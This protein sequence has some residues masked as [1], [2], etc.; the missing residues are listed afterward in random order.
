MDDVQRLLISLEGRFNKYE[1]DL[2]RTKNRTRTNFRAME[3]QAADSAKKMDN[4]MAGALKSFG[5][6]LAGG[7]IGGLAIGGLDQ[8]VSR[9]G[10]IA[11][12]IASIGN[13]AKR[14]GL[15]T[16]AFQELGYVAQQNRIPVDA[17]VDGMKELNLR[18][19]EF[20]VTGKGSAAEAFQRLG[21]SAQDLKRKLEDPS[22]LLVEIIGR[23]Q[24]LDRA[25]Q[26][27]IADEIFGGTGGERF[28]ELI[29]QGAEGIRRAIKEANDLGIVMDDELIR[30]A[31]ELDRKFQAIGNTISTY[32]KQ[33]VV[34]LVGA[35]D[36]FLDR[37]N[38]V[39]EQSDRNVQNRLLDTYN[40][41]AAEKQKLADL[42]QISLGTPADLMNITAS[43]KEIERLTAEAM[44]LRD[45]LDRRNGYREDFIYKT[46]E[47]AK[48]AKPPLDSLNN[49]LTGTGSAAGAGAKGLDSF[50]SAVRALKDEVPDLANGLAQLDAQTRIDQAYRAALGQARTMGEVYLANELRGNALS[51]VAVRSAT[52]DP[53]RYLTNVLASGKSQAHINGLASTFAEKLAKMLASMPDDLKGS[54]T[55]NSGYRS[56]ERQ[57]QL[58]LQALKKYGSP[59]AARKWVAPPGNSQHNKGNAAD[60]GYSS[61]AARQW[62]HGNASRFGLTFPLSNENWHIEDAEARQQLNSQEME[63]K[64]AVATE[65][66]DAYR[67]ITTEARNF[68]LGQQTERQ[69]LDMT[70]DAAAAL[71]YEQQMLAEAQR[72]GI[73]LTDQQ[74]Q[75]IANLAAGM[76]GAE[77]A[78]QSYVQT[79]E[80]ASAAAQFFGQQAVDALSGLLTGTM[81][82]EHALQQLLQ[83]LVKAALQAALLGEGPLAGLL[84][85]KP[86]A[87][88]GNGSSKKGLGSILGAIFGFAD[89]GY[90]GHGGKHEPAGVVHRGEY[91]MSKRAVERIGVANLEA[92]HRGALKA[93]YADGGYVG[94]PRLPAANVA[95][96]NQNAPQIAISAPVTVN[97]NGGTPE[98]NADLAKQVSRQMEA[99][100]RGVVADEL[101]RQMRPG[102][103]L[104]NG[105]SR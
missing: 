92:M 51:A 16:K 24:Q 49:A 85:G 67:Q 31:D 23:L 14:A 93:G 46:G 69:A 64:I 6:G 19:D 37:F 12:N 100:M 40:D 34:G 103:M 3:K 2:D 70:T 81:T 87:P 32:T 78:V 83:T 77:G 99:T 84:G 63:R 65:Q 57:Q 18:A 25:A 76:A 45:I 54:V 79:Q 101:R 36:D 88:T 102:N 41:I 52:D 27:R 9:V 22:T 90:T 71:R 61:D 104:N 68:I 13:E 94:Q 8:I 72:A 39:E 86:K 97:A 7:V 20:V 62:V 80:Q 74:R 21:Y 105:R 17:L 66:A 82:A 58:W 59:D 11:K 42:Q 15:S 4:V 5:K 75:E 91:V 96:A 73:T 1:R 47:D 55:I 95:P 28:V 10:D 60:L 26:I 43:Q 38:K 89:G 33:A 56:V 35:M 50:A 29:D 98:Q 48:Y 30:R 53:T 44:R